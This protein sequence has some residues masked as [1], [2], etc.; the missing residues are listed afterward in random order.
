M[1]KL[2]YSLR[3]S[4]SAVFSLGWDGSRRGTRKAP[5]LVLYHFLERVLFRTSSKR[6][7]AVSI[8]SCVIL[9]SNCILMEI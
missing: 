8:S 9:I 3:S 6:F 4:D 7:R 5:R 2:K 1:T